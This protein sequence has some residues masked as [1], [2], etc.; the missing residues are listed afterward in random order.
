M[1]PFF[2]LIVFLT[3]L[4]AYINGQADISA[5]GSILQPWGGGL[6]SYYAP[7]YNYYRSG[8]YGRTTY[9]NPYYSSYSI[10][11]DLLT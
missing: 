1:N 9:G 11:Y 7:S 4:A 5:S 6:G 8:Y 3:L 10:F 2:V